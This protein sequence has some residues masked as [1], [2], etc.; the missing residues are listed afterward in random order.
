MTAIRSVLKGYEPNIEQRQTINEQYEKQVVLAVNAFEEKNPLKQKNYT[1]YRE[2]T[3]FPSSSYGEQ[4][5]EVPKLKEA[6]K[7]ASVDFRGWPFIFVSRDPKDLYVIQDGIES[8][9]S[10]PD[11]NSNDRT[12]FWRIYTSGLFYHRSLMWEEF[13]D[14]KQTGVVDINYVLSGKHKGPTMDFVALTY[15]VAEAVNALTLLYTAMDMTEEPITAIFKI[16]GTEGR[17]LTSYAP[18]RFLSMPYIARIPEIVEERTY[19]L[20]EWKAGIIDLS[21]DVIK[22]IF[23]KFNWEN[24]SISV[25]KEDIEKLFSRRL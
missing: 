16:K 15:Y 22:A 5:F 25:F 18:G 11:F 2:V 13:Q 14:R 12:D 8:L 20:N 17:I 24:P 19:S 21:I 1:G 10:F 4:R 7:Q 3:F 6:L 9:V 23:L